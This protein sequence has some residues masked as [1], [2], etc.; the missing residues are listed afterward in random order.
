MAKKKAIKTEASKSTDTGPSK[1]QKLRGNR[2]FRLGLILILM[3][4]VAVLFFFYEKARIWLAII[5]FTLLAALGLEVSQNDWD[6]GELWRTK[7]FEESKVMRDESG[8]V[9]FDKG[10]NIVTD[11]S[12]GKKSDDYNCA[13]FSTQPEAQAFFKKVGGAGNDVNRLDGDKDSQ[14]CETLP[15]L[16][17]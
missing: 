9:L 13:D 11:K 4:I 5:F 3:L 8:N 7:S 17:N 6:L 10:G 2:N 16:T 1:L 15:Q 12:L 14:A